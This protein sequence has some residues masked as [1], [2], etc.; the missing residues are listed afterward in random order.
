MD[1]VNKKTG[2]I[3]EDPMVGK[4]SFNERGEELPNS[5]PMALP[6]GFRR[7]QSLGE[8]MKYLLRSQQLADAAEAAG[9]ETFD[10]A[11]DFSCEEQDPLDGTPYEDN[12]DPEFPGAT[13]RE[14]ELR[15]GYVKE[16]PL[17][18]KLKAKQLLLD[19][20]RKKGIYEKNQ[21]VPKNPPEV[22]PEAPEEP[23][24]TPPCDDAEI[25][26]EPKNARRRKKQY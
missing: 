15:A 13:A 11:D 12:F 24:E 19:Y 9:A 7:V 5:T 8:R 21:N 16:Y 25:S 10:E 14:Q 26:V 20:Q 23:E 4:S 2:E 1:S 22:S 3:K 17:E 6:V 18:K